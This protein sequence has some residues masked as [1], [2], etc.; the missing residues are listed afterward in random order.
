MY[1]SLPLMSLQEATV[2]EGEGRYSV[3]LLVFERNKVK[4]RFSDL[5]AASWLQHII[6]TSA[7]VRE[8]GTCVSAEQ[9]LPLPQTVMSVLRRPARGG[10]SS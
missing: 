10:P 2:T 7:W 1:R 3:L 8:R 4:T 6:L 9:P 5:D